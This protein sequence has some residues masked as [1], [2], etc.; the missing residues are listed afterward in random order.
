MKRNDGSISIRRDKGCPAWGA[1]YCQYNA[2]ADSV[3]SHANADIRIEKQFYVY[4]SANTLRPDATTE[5]AVG[6]RIQVR[7]T[8]R[9]S[10]TSTSWRSPTTVA[11]ASNRQ[12]S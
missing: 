4:N 8:I 9:S 2:P 1:V 11:H 10:A 12:T 6:D 5:F 3:K 7:L